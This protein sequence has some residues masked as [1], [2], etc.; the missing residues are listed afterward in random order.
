LQTLRA[1]VF[2]QDLRN[3]LPRQR[4]RGLLQIFKYVVYFLGQEM[5]AIHRKGL[6]NLHGGAFQLTKFF[7]HGLDLLTPREM[8]RSLQE[9]QAARKEG[10]A[11]LFEPLFLLL[12]ARKYAINELTHGRN[13]CLRRRSS[14]S[15]L[16]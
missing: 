16:K 14:R 9:R 3:W 8:E 5:L 15:E 12:H 6:A 7:N 11:Q 13:R 10:G 4:R 1:Q 2:L